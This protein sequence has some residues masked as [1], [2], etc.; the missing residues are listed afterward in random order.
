MPFT[1]THSW[2]LAATPERV[3][4]ALTN[5]AELT[6][7]FA[8]GATVEPRV[9][10]VYRFWGRHTP[11]TPPEDA[12]RQTVTRYEPDVALGFDWPLNEVDT[13]V[14]INLAPVEKGTTLTV[15]HHMSGDLHLPRQRELIDEHW[16]MAMDNLSAHLAGGSG[17]VLPDYF[18][19]WRDVRQ[20][21]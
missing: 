3:F 17:I 12:A 4:R 1:H 11:G 16:R 20:K 13:Q 15:V 7:W 2:A 8:E 6:Q 19:Q 14:T 9:G 18:D 10:G 5:A 21:P